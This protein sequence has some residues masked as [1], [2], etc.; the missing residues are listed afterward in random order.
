MS[1]P[2]VIGRDG[3]QQILTPTLTEEEVEKL[4]RSAADLQA[5]V[6]GNL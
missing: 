2:A 5:A 3:A 6:G 1:L 4:K